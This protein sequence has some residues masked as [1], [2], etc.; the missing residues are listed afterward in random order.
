MTS[1][2]N[3]Q[4]WWRTLTETDIAKTAPKA[5]EYSA[6]DLAI[7]GDVL[8]KWT[9]GGA[10]QPDRIGQEMAVMLYLLGKV[11]RAIG[12]YQEG[13]VPSDDTL[14]DIRIYAVMLKR[15]R[16]KGAWPA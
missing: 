15:I 14:D 16:D 11:A 6:V 7:M 4:Q 10:D 1:N 2:D 13:H 12:A 3:W 5:K 8:R 9:I